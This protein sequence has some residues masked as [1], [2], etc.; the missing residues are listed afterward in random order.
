M[1]IQFSNEQEMIRESAR[2]FLSDACP[3]SLVRAAYESPQ[4]ALG[5][6]WKEMAKLG[7]T[8]LIVPE[9]Y[10]GTEAGFQSLA[11]LL[12]EM[13]RVCLPVPFFSTV[14]LGGLCLMELADERHKAEL[15]PRL[16]QGDLLLTLAL[17]EGASEFD[18]ASMTFAARPD[19]G[20]IRVAGRKFL[21]PDAQSTD[22]LVCVAGVEG[23]T[24]DGGAYNLVLVPRSK[25]GVSC[26]P[27]HTITGNSFCEVICDDVRLNREAFLNSKPIPWTEI[28]RVLCK[29]AV[30]KSAEMIGGAQ[31]AMDLALG[32]AKER[33][34]FDKPIGAFQ[35]IQHHCVNMLMQ[36]ESARWLT[37]RCVGMI[38]RG[39]LKTAY[40]A[41]A[42]A[43]S[44]QA[45][46]E[47]IRLAHQVMGGIGYCEDHEMPMYF[48]HARQCEAMLGDTDTL[49]DIIAGEF[50]DVCPSCVGESRETILL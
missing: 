5:P 17:Q 50:L 20:G 11:I 21:V 8:G 13:G 36:V 33:R 35:A 49:L 18:R 31:R 43:W 22:Y 9:Q 40:A 15:L 16:V 34:Q 44:N 38:D 4:V 41:V 29:A 7:W 28:Q 14:V 12:E 6:L 45:Y 26:A 19:S 10:G 1:R 48:R 27:L 25:P 2:R 32:Y 37:Y 30:A 46:R 42:K 23:S 3:A 39:R 24:D 47:V